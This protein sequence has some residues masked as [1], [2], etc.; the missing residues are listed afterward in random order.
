MNKSH[1]PRADGFF[2]V[3]IFHPEF[4]VFRFLA[5]FYFYPGRTL[6]PTEKYEAAA[7]DIIYPLV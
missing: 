6:F 1:L 5:L 3:T 4:R 7:L 2:Y